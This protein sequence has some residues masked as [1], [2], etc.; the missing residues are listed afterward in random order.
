MKMDIIFK[1][2]KNDMIT[3]ITRKVNG[4]LHTFALAS[5]EIENIHHG[6]E[7]KMLKEAA[8]ERVSKCPLMDKK[9]VNDAFLRELVLK[10]LDKRNPDVADN[11]TWGIVINDFISDPENVDSKVLRKP[12]IMG[13][14]D[15]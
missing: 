10:F 1:E 3:T 14:R 8:A 9:Y 5:G 7:I 15:E 12:K 2:N 11:V 4:E 6:H 13:V